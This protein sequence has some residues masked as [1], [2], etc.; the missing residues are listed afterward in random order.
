MSDEKPDLLRFANEY[1][2][3]DVDLYELLGVDALTPK[4]DIHRAWRKRS[5]KYHPDKAGENFDAAKWELFERAR[6]V[7]SDVV[8][9]T[10]YDQSLKAK[11]LRKQER[12][13]MDKEH[14]KFAD[15]L[16]ARENAFR[17]QRQQKDQRN[18]EAVE[19]ER[20]RL[21]EEQRMHEEERQRQAHA[22]Q[23][24]EDLAEARRRLKERKEEK[25]RRKQV[26]KSMKATGAVGKASGPAN[27]VVAVPGEYI[28]DLGN[29]K[30]MYWELVCDK[31]RAVQAVRNL[32]KAGFTDP[33]QLKQ[34]E[35]GVLEARRMIYEAEMKFQQEMA[36]F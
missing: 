12:E 26:K 36:T 32:Q 23:E 5:L 3:Q 6:D 30:K 21:A 15:D 14:K 25:A 16:E 1:A 10:A 31:L 35:D 24:M 18:K 28:A 22:A 11:L 8:A 27:G 7:L 29:V 4:E 2:D 13:A 19:K 17:Q 34:A 9:R 20:A 33:Q